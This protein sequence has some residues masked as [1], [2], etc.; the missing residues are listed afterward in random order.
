MNAQASSPISRPMVVQSTKSIGIQ[1]LL[2][3]F[4][5]PFG[6]FY[7]TVKGALIMIFGVPI[8][9]ALIAI[10]GGFGQSPLATIAG[11]LLALFGWWIG[12]FVWGAVAVKS[13][14]R[15][16]LRGEATSA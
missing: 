1:I 14:N 11:L 15:K 16:L 4:L 9:A 13:Y 6:L 2:V 3:L 5:G 8:A 10:V 12:S 7:S